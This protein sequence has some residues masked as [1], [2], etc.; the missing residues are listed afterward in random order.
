MSN[1]IS[2]IFIFSLPRAGS[3]LTQLILSTH[4]DISTTSETWILLP[5]LYALKK[6]GVF[7]EYS[8]ATMSVAIEDFCQELTHGVEDYYSELRH[9]ILRLYS[10]ASKGTAK[11]FLDKTPRYHLVVEEI[12]R[13]FPEGKFIF[14]MRNPLAVVASLIE[15]WGKGKWNLYIYKVDL[16]DGLANLAAT[17]HK[18]KKTAH[19]VKYEN[20]ISNPTEESQRM[21]DYLDLSWD[22]SLLSQ[23]NKVELRGR[24]RGDLFG[25]KQYRSISKEPLD[26]WKSILANPIRKTWCRRYLRWIGRERLS[27]MGY[28]FD[29]L[30]AELNAIPFNFR[31]VGSDAMRAT[32]GIMHCVLEPML[33]KDKLKK[34]SALHRIYRHT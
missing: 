25:T 10:K 7:A 1:D 33:V 3:T 13:L 23:F 20:L 8:H 32:L 29:T 31:Y 5:Y 30:R 21:F 4:N 22:A 24:M 19:A 27:Q 28:D 34:I 6:R 16:F 18:H 11:Y 17:Y 15:S 9:F 2:P 26:K 12:I 14:L